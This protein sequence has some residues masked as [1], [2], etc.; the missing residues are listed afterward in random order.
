M[1]FSRQFPWMLDSFLLLSMSAMVCFAVFMESWWLFGSSSPYASL[2]R[3]GLLAGV[4]ALALVS[5]RFSLLAGRA[6]PLVAALAL[7]A[8]PRPVRVFEAAMRGSSALDPADLVPA[9]IWLL[10]FSVPLLLWAAPAALSGGSVADGWYADPAGGH[11]VRRFVSGWWT[12]DVRGGGVGQC[13]WW[14]SAEC[15]HAAEYDGQV[16]GPVE[17]HS[18]G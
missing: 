3:L 5:G 18:T 15:D 16:E 2:W 12:E 4:P 8:V 11:H 9:L 17:R 13:D 1:R 7:A 14:F 10:G 6:W